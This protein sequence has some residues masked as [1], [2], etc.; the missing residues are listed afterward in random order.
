LDATAFA[1]DKNLAAIPA[2]TT[3]NVS[4][5]KFHQLGLFVTHWYISQTKSDAQAKRF[6]PL[7]IGPP[8]I[9][10]NY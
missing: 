10:N 8:N 7:P 4:T 6:I 3:D 2:V 9:A 5:I 1:G